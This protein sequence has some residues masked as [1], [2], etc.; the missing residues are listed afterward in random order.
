MWLMAGA[1]QGAAHTHT[2]LLGEG[3]AHL[4]L[5]PHEGPAS[6]IKV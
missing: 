3:R 6:G 4:L 2:P 1:L 5:V